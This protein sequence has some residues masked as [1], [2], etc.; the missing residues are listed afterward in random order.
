MTEQA[1]TTGSQVGVV[2]LGHGESASRLLRAARDIVSSGL[3]DLVAVD[4]GE[5]Q[6]PELERTLCDVIAQAD[7]G[8][9]VLLLVDLLG[10][11]PCA[12]GRRE[13]AGRGLTTVGGL[14]LAMLL[15]LASLDRGALE[16][17]ELAAAC[18]D[19]GRRAVATLEE[20]G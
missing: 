14:N 19:S 9:G 12:C 3:D 7:E 11:S 6:T 4:A 15:K 17:S 5:G 18:V 1:Q 13:G 8:R 10:S 20:N 2:I 16:P